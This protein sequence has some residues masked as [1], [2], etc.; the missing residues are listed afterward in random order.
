[1]K[2]LSLFATQLL[3]L[4]LPILLLSQLRPYYFNA[5]D[6]YEVPIPLSERYHFDEILNYL[7]PAPYSIPSP[8][9]FSYE[10]IQHM[11]DVRNIFLIL[12][13][14]LCV[15]AVSIV[16]LKAKVKTPVKILLNQSFKIHFVFCFLL[17]VFGFLGALTWPQSFIVFHQ[18][19]F[20]QNNYWL[21]D[22]ATSNLIKFLPNQI[23]QELGIL[24]L[25]L[26]IIELAICYYLVRH[27]SR[28]NST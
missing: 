2:Y 10:D 6:R 15:C 3:L 14:V 7:L 25:I 24:Y 19:L 13:C 21:L 27:E 16:F 22:P 18:I 4:L 28:G 8:R 9:F 11:H 5:F 17:S 23:F 20:P 12:Y 26:L 1:M